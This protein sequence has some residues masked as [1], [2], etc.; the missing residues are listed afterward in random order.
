MIGERPFYSMCIGCRV[1][2]SPYDSYC[3]LLKA[4]M[5]LEKGN[6]C[7]LKSGILF[8]YDEQPVLREFRI[9]ETVGIGV[10]NPRAISVPNG[11][12]WVT[13]ERIIDQGGCLTCQ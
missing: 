1:D 11:C 2:G 4:E 10:Y 13:G 8:I 12:L 7:L 3:S 6:K 5:A 9:W